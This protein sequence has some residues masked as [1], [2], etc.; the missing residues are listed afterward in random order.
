[1]HIH[2]TDKINVG[3]TVHADFTK[4]ST[5]VVRKGI[6]LAKSPTGVIKVDFGQT[7][8]DGTRRTTSFKSCGEERGGD[9]FHPAR[10]ITSDRFDE[11]LNE[12]NRR[13]N[14]KTVR[15]KIQY[16]A[17]LNFDEP[18]KV[19]EALKAAIAAVESIGE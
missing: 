5:I 4:Y 2:N 11:L 8:F 10:L 16:A 18:V 14:M 6:V 19:I 13:Q 1:M 7:Y 3:D 17:T 15:D 9:R 12:Q